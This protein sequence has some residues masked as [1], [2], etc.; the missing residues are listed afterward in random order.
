MWVTDTLAMGTY[1]CR[2]VFVFE[3]ADRV[4][5]RHRGLFAVGCA[6]LP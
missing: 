2:D 3:E 1:G 6:L 5:L 4:C